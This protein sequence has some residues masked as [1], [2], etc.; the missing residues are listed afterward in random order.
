M[1][2]VES[3]KERP[4]RGIKRKVLG[5]SLLSVGMLNTMLTLKSGVAPDGFNYLIIGAGLL[6]FCSGLFRR[7]P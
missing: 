1:T 2:V 5:V 4:V 6:L 3:K 7:S